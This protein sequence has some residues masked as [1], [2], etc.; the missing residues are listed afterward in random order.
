MPDGTIDGK[1]KLFNDSKLGVFVT[2]AVAS[3]F[4]GALDSLIE[5]L[6]NVDLSHSESWWTKIAAAAVATL[7]GLFTAYKARRDKSHRVT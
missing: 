3:I 6:G 5:T 4:S 7:L 1:N 2:A